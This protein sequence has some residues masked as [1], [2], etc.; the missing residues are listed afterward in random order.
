MDCL[1]SSIFAD[2][3]GEYE[4]W[5]DDTSTTLRN[6]FSPFSICEHGRIPLSRKA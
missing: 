6:Q 1:E 4:S 3:Y 5:Y 2:S